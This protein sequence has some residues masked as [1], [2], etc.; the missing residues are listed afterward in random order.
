M[1]VD[2]AVDAGR[3]WVTVG[4][5]PVS[6]PARTSRTAI[7]TAAKKAAGAAYRASSAR[8]PRRATAYQPETAHTS[9]RSL[10]A[11]SPAAVRQS[12]ALARNA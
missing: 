1:P 5:D 7:V 2:V 12:A 10:A 4:G 9:R 11:S 6:R 8:Q 3:P